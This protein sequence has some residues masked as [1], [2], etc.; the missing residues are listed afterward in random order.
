MDQRPEGSLEEFTLT[1]LPGC[2]SSCHQL[3]LL[4][5]DVCNC[6]NEMALIILAILILLIQL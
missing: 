4:P 1:A 2:N 5:R 3:I 6:G